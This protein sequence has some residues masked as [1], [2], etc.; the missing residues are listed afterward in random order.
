[1]PIFRT[2]KKIAAAPIIVGAAAALII[3]AILFFTVYKRNRVTTKEVTM[4]ESE[5][6][7]ESLHHAFADEWLAYYQYWVGALVVQGPT[8]KDVIFELKEHAQD[9]LRHAGMLA[10]RIIDL[11]ET[12]I[13]EP[14]NWYSHAI[15]GY[16][17]P[18][19]AAIPKILEQ[20][21]KGE[22]CAIEFYKSLL[23][24]TKDNDE[25]THK[26]IQEILNDEIEHK[27]DLEKL[28]KKAH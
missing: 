9:E 24:L 26:I 19:D 1:M 17:A 28:S 22:D 18:T 16:A 25:I 5:K 21:I 8:Q 3:G 20:N 14:K 4:V 23:L 11:G 15:C 13:L 6:I 7:M 27:E 2:S 10:E 12:P